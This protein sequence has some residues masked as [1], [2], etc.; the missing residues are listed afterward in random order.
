MSKCPACGEELRIDDYGFIDYETDKGP[1]ALRQKF[2]EYLEV[3]M[4]E[5]YVCHN[6]GTKLRKAA[7]KATYKNPEI[8][9]ITISD[10]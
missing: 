1:M 7:S 6:C 5:N 4:F 2:P 10:S 3:T 8:L 9:E